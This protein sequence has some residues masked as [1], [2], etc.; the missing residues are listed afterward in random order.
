MDRKR[1]NL[2][3]FLCQ[4]IVSDGVK[5]SGQ[6]PRA[7]AGRVNH[8]VGRMKLAAL[9]LTDHDSARHPPSGEEKEQTK[10][11]A[12]APVHNYGLTSSN[13]QLL[14]PYFA[15]LDAWLLRTVALC[16]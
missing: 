13:E 16:G 14:S 7:D 15:G 2:S 10:H 5:R 8:M 4:A 6:M 3:R 1:L 11:R 9:T 12:D